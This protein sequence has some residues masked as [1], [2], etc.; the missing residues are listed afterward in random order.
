MA[1]MQFAQY[2]MSNIPEEYINNYAHEML[3]KEEQVR[4]LAEQCVEREIGKKIRDR[5]TLD[6]K[7]VTLED[8]NK[9]FE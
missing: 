4:Q 9:L 3:K 2:G 1:R 7:N 5:I 6:T 8:F